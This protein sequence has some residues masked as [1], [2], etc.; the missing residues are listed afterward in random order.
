VVIL[1]PDTSAAGTV[2]RVRVH[3][4]KRRGGPPC[5]EGVDVYFNRARQRFVDS[6][7][8]GETMADGPAHYAGNDLGDDT[9]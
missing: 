3:V 9:W 1:V 8:D 4:D 5:R 7:D 2:V 6:A